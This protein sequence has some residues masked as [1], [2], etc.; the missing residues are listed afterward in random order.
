VAIYNLDT[1]TG[2]SLADSGVLNGTVL[3]GMRTPQSLTIANVYVPGSLR[4]SF[5]IVVTETK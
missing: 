2:Q 5:R 1:T 3:T 4:L